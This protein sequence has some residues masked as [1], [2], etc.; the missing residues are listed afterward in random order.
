M[1]CYKYT[2]ARAA[3]LH[4]APAAGLRA[5]AARGRLPTPDSVIFKLPLLQ[6]LAK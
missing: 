1:S 4:A 5:Q 3:H 2:R 6:I